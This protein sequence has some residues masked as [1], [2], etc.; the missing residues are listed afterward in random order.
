MP[1]T[2]DSR[3]MTLTTALERNNPPLPIFRTFVFL[4]LQRE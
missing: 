1:S 3:V 2:R 4:E